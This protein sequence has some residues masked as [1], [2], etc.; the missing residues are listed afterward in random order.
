MTTDTQEQTRVDIN[1]PQPH[2]NGQ[3]EFVACANKL[4]INKSGRRWGKTVGVAIKALCAFCGVCALCLGEGCP[5][6]NNTG[7]VRPKRVLYAAP[8]AEQVGKFWHEVCKALDG[9]V[10]AKALKKNE[11]E[12][13][14]EVPGTEIRIKAK[15]AWN[16]NTLRGDYADLLILEEYQLMNED[17]WTEVGQPM[18][19]DTDGHAVFIFTPPSLKSE[20]A[21]KA[22][23]P[24]HAS[25]MFRKAE[26]D[27]TG[28]WKTFHFTTFE[29][30]T[31]NQKA[32]K[33]LAKNWEG[34]E[35]S[36]RREILAED[37]DIEQGWLVYGKFDES[38]CQIKRF[39][40]PKTWPVYTGHDFGS[41]NPAALFIAE[42][43]LPLPDNAPRYLRY[44]DYV[45]FLEYV[46]GGGFSTRQHVDNFR[47]LAVG[48]KMQMSVGGNITTEDEIRQGYGKEGWPIRAPFVTRVNAQIDKVIS[49]IENNQ[50]YIFEDLYQL[51]GQIANCMWIL[52]EEK[53]CTNKIKDESRYHLLSA[54][55]YVA[56]ALK[57]AK[58]GEQTSNVWHWSDDSGEP[59]HIRRRRAKIASFKRL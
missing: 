8:T 39:E 44:G 23:D 38:L 47:N 56:T 54:L 17:A 52:D 19:V 45:A 41:A 53:R 33:E 30:P 1:I 57:I 43:K 32:L 10:K 34:S 48:H 22:R 13:Y 15:T 55:R 42:V 5:R 12:K 28:L 46:P 11:T 25:K 9:P 6:C 31:L 18:L 24:R 4:L 36:Y 16:A 26:A 14:I 37:D 29:N 20:G 40:I 35:D 27:K 51:L 21:T 58:G 2:S 7:R 50:F 3:K 59:E 49:L